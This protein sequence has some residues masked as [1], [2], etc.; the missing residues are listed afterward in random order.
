MAAPSVPIGPGSYQMKVHPMMIV[1][2][3]MNHL[4]LRS[5]IITMHVTTQDM[6]EV[7]DTNRKSISGVSLILYGKR[8]IR[9]NAI[10]RGTY[11]LSRKVCI[12]FPF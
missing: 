5:A 3:G 12:F 8:R 11:S 9:V 1:K 2:M 7:T 10:S 6:I 4:C